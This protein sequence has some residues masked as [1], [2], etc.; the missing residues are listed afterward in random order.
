MTA[1]ASKRPQRSG[2]DRGGPEVVVATVDGRAYFDFVELLGE[3]KLKY[4]SKLPWEVSQGDIRLLLTTKRELP[5]T[6]RGDRVLYEELSGTRLLDSS[7]VLSCLLKN[8]RDT[9]VVGIDPGKN[10]GIACLYRGFN[11]F[12]TS[13]DSLDRAVDLVCGVLRVQS[14]DKLVRIGRGDRPKAFYL[15]REIR[16]HCSEAPRIEIVDERGTSKTMRAPIHK[17][18]RRDASS[19]LIIARKQGSEFH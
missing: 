8:R 7:K 11:L 14:R 10:T 3:M 2:G 13:C 19:A 4:S 15:A 12:A 1:R 9:L 6:F 5:V 16:G 17:H 18:G